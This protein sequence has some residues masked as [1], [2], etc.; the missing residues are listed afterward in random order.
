MGK[1]KRWH[2]YLILA[3]IILTFINILPTVI[4]YSKPLRKPIDETRA[5]RVAT[6]IIAR[7][8]TLESESQT[9][10]KSFCKLLGIK[11]TKI[12]LKSDDTSLFEITFKDEHDANLFK[13]FLPRGGA[14]IPFVPA[15][16][17]LYLGTPKDQ[18]IVLVSRQI[19]VHLDPKEVDRLF[20]YVPK[21]SDEKISER[22]R[23]LVYDRTEQLA[24]GFGGPSK[25]ALLVAKLAQNG[26]DPQYDEDTI[27]LA[28]EIVEVTKALGENNPIT[29]RYYGTFTQG[30]D[31][32]NLQQFIARLDAAKSR[33]DTQREPIVAEQKKLQDEGLPL[34]PNTE[35]QL[36]QLDRQRD[37]L[38]AASG[39]IRQ[40]I[41]D[42]RTGNKPLDHAQI[43]QIF[44][45]SAQ[46]IDPKD[47][48][49]FVMLN[50]RN[51]FVESLVI[52]WS[53][54]K[55]ETKFYD[56]VQ[57]IRLATTGKREQ[58]AYQK[59]KLNQVI[60]DE[61]SRVSRLS[62]ERI[63]S[64]GEDFAVQ[65]TQLTNPQTFLEIDLGY[66][67]KKQS[68]QITE[69]IDSTWLP[70]H[71]DLVRKNFPV[72][73]YDTFKILSSQEQ[74]LGLV[75]YAP[76][77]YQTDPPKG[78][79]MDSIYVIARGLE[80]IIQKYREAP[81]APG[82]EEL[83]NNIEQ[84][85]TLLQRKGFIGYPGTSYGIAS[86]YRN[87]YI[88][89][90]DDY[91]STLLSA[92]RERFQVKGS[93]RFALLDFTD[94]EQRILTLNQ[95]QE[96]KQEDL[97][98]W[99]D[100]YEKAQVDI[101]VTRRYEVPPPTKN[102]YWENFKLT[103]AKYFRGDDRKILKWGLD[104][105][106]G[107]T[108]RIGLRDRNNQPVTNPDDL[109]QAVNELYTRV[110]KMGVSERT[111]RIVGNNI[112]LD[113]PGSQ[114]L[115]ATELI[116]ASAMYFHIVNEKFSPRNP[117]LGDEVNKFLQN[118]WNEAV[119]T[120]RK[121]MESINEIAWEQLGG[122]VITGE[123]NPRSDVAKNLYE[124]GLRIASP[125]DTRKSNAFDDTLSMISMYRGDDT[126]EW[127]GQTHPLV[128]TFHNYA[129]EGANLTN[130]QVGYDPSKG[131][132]LL[133]SV[134]RSYDHAPGSPRDEFY[135]WTSQFSEEKIGGTLKEAYSQGR[136]WRMAIILNDEIVTSPSLKAALRD[137]GT[138]EGR[139]SQ[140]EITQLIADLKAGSLSFT[141]Y[142]LSEQNVSPELGQEERTK[143]IIASIVGLALVAVAM[144]SYYRFAGVV[145]T[146]A[147]LLNLLIMWAVLQNIDAALTLS[148][149]AG[150]VLTIGMA[151]DANVLVFERVREEFNIS[152]RIASAIQSGYKKAYSAI[153]DS[154]ITTIIAALILIQ[155][156]SGPI[157]G[158]AITSII[159]LVSSMFTA[160][161]MTRYF[162]SGWVQNPKHKLL[163]MSKFIGETK[164][165]FLKHSKKVICVSL[166]LIVCGSYFFISQKN[167]L[168]G[169]DFTGGY[170]ISVEL[171]KN[172][173]DPL[174]RLQTTDALLAA[175]ATSNDF[176]IRE[177]SHPNQLRIQLGMGMEQK[178]HPF[179]QMA[180][181][182]NEKEF[183]YEYE[184]NPRLEWIVNA[185]NKSG[186]KIQKS[187]LENL[188]KNWTMM[189]GQ[190]SKTMRNNAI[191]ALTL[192]LASIL[193]YIT[194]RFEFK[195]AV[196]AVV[197]LTHDV[198][199][200]IGLLS[201]FHFM[202]FPVQI[203][204]TVVA[205]IMTIIGYSLNDTIVVF[206]RIREDIK[207]LRK[208]KFHEIVNHALNI[209]LARTIMTSGTTLLVLL[210]LIFLGG[211]SIFDFS[212]VM[213]IGVVVGTISS[214]FIAS[215]IMLYFHDR[216]ERLLEKAQ[217]H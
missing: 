31:T 201:M 34:D 118:V 104:L 137:G 64:K 117:T 39:I 158:F 1:R 42:F 80:N 107:K 88:F 136:G 134:K 181:T 38:D 62:D 216:E 177:L 120:N 21:Y 54:N 154:N 114:A 98:K 101:D 16:L 170:S 171:E 106:G 2:F 212:L 146:C 53:N 128:V 96:R 10:L 115:S 133:F 184:K 99:K 131:N 86:E 109:N 213:T 27:G 161:F 189:S 11:P 5:K 215:P 155:F 33:I 205:A 135:A 57:L 15:Q 73:T 129:L 111:I 168:F 124:N 60:I 192:A 65:L 157:K 148:G 202:G 191:M 28:K 50:G 167:T 22:Y 140:R 32:N 36:S 160:L 41:S 138:I 59:E 199:V 204:L 75:V 150:I 108:V 92:T 172:P 193:I 183:T 121:D 66:L 165:D 18:P 105:S 12:Q 3:V 156:D 55:I 79:R 132:M 24:L 200:T 162:F 186:L 195:Y 210:C 197:A 63:T 4:Y 125:K 71:P 139:F 87:D 74:R 91:Y 81:N 182:E 179:Y 26:S 207:I 126:S 8:N 123:I 48:L 175:G 95:I 37:A 56:D 142:I 49:Q 147:V 19:G 196:G 211:R 163:T 78:F 122:D 9:W 130:I 43:R 44:S 164:I 100:E 190:F 145:A 69:Q 82:N 153:L 113:F 20:H 29:K 112:I 97:L 159:G 17:E 89:E 103:L 180:E 119:V 149:I 70:D 35:Q 30:D 94:V 166:I 76:T 84:L 185:L 198:I 51:P 188:N 47:P 61:I 203:D 58:E 194:V 206:D 67:A 77:M 7:V 83:R 187:D 143:G 23:E 178:G 93:K 141:P 45:K 72:M 14:L 25:A 214:L 208:M 13:R 173:D 217:A 102:I 110:N 85:T 176:Q 209:T 174:Y 116:K 40:N 90:L 46:E 52:D 169:M 68:D 6:E 127:Y 144:V 152:G 151:V